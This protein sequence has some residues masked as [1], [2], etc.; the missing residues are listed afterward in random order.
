MGSTSRTW[1]APTRA[2]A[3]LACALAC[4]LL[5]SCRSSDELTASMLTVTSHRDKRM[6]WIGGAMR[7]PPKVAYVIPTH[8]HRHPLVEAGA[9]SWRLGVA[10][11]L[12]TE[13]MAEGHIEAPYEVPGE[14]EVGQQPIAHYSDWDRGRL[15]SHWTTESKEMWFSTPDQEVLSVRHREAARMAAALRLAHEALFASPDGRQ[16][17]FLVLG[18]EQTMFIHEHIQK[19]DMRPL[20]YSTLTLPHST[21][22]LPY[23]NLTL[24]YSTLT[25]PCSTLTV[26]DRLHDE[27]SSLPHKPLCTLQR[28][29]R[30]DLQHEAVYS[31]HI[32][33]FIPFQRANALAAHAVGIASRGQLEPRCRPMQHGSRRLP[34]A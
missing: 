32:N 29:A 22:T 1:T 4:A 13:G 3:A 19:R 30:N 18:D 33:L 24:P 26:P 9:Q 15:W 16:Y 20:P 27:H 25:L 14:A 8:S 28:V 34:A 5:G 21:L 7:P 11:V 2:R 31:A 10:A 12:V 6:T 17:E 23:S